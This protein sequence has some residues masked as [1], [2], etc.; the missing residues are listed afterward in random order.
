MWS[1][2][3]FHRE[4]RYCIRIEHETGHGRESVTLLASGAL[5]INAHTLVYHAAHDPCINHCLTSSIECESPYLDAGRFSIV[6]PVKII[7]RTQSNEFDAIAGENG[8]KLAEEV[9]DR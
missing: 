4:T 5:T 1:V 7:L 9:A 3:P 6:S 2:P 8:C